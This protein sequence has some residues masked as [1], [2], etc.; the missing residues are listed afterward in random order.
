[1]TMTDEEREHL[2]KFVEHFNRMIDKFILGKKAKL[3]GQS[4]TTN[5]EARLAQFANRAARLEF[6]ELPSTMR[7]KITRALTNVD[8]KYKFLQVKHKDP[9]DRIII[10]NTNNDFKYSFSKFDKWNE[11]YKL[12]LSQF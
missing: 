6:N 4:A 10:V 2:T 7:A 12:A 11:S 1:M 3:L 5:V 8:K 9:F